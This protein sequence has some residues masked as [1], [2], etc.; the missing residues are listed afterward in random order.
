MGILQPHDRRRR[1]DRR[2]DLTEP[3]AIVV[4]SLDQA[5]AAAAAAEAMGSPLVLRSAPGAGGSAGVG[6]F[7]ALVEAVAD[8]HP[9]L[10]VTFV[11]DCADE[12]GTVLGALRRGLKRLRFGGP[13]EVAAKLAAIAAA[14]GAALDEDSRPALDLLGQLDPEAISRRWLAGEP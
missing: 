7:T 5:L 2:T 4:H 13:P 11:L 10:P 9:A 3:P 6:W 1:G 14:E 12:A 8:R